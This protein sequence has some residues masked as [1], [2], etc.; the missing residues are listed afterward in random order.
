MNQNY[1]RYSADSAKA[2]YDSRVSNVSTLEVSLQEESCAC[3]CA[4]SSRFRGKRSTKK[5][6]RFLK[7]LHLATAK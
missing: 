1:H 2:L 7:K 3:K 5:L 4:N 6:H